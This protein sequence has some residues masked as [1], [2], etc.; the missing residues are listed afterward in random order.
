MKTRRISSI[1]IAW[2]CL[3]AQSVNYDFEGTID[4]YFNKSVLIISATSHAC[5][6]F[7]VYLAVTSEQRRRGLMFVRDL[8]KFSGMLF[9]YPASRILSIWMKNTYISLDMI[10]IEEDGEVAQAEVEES[11]AVNAESPGSIPATKLRRERLT[12]ERSMLQVDVA[13][14]EFDISG[15]TA[16]VRGQQV[17]AAENS[18]ERRS[19]KAPLAGV[20]ERRYKEIGEWVALG[21]PICQVV[22]MDRLRVEGFLSSRDH[23]PVLV[24]GRPV[25]V[26]LKDKQLSAK[27]EKLVNRKLEFSGYVRLE[28]RPATA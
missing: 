1:L 2:L 6:L 5:Y 12:A 14:L 20:I 10:F 9:V 25:T 17:K 3:S 4:E 13:K 19:I 15:I 11:E 8:P 27:L 16:R 18:L 23:P 28:A 24:L 22:R 21:E 26:R 7:D